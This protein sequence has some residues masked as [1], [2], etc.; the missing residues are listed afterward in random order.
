MVR[1]D[2]IGLVTETR[3]AHGVHEAI[4]ETVR[5]VLAEIRSVTRS[6]YYNALNAGIHPEM[7]FKLTLDADY[8]DERFLR[9]RGQKWRV[10]RTYLTRDGGIEITAER[11]DEN[12]ETEK[13]PA[14][15][16]GNGEG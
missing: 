1:A 16:T 14:D 6:E 10:V 5:E 8:H 3:S 15:D 2:V 13:E 4:T 11:D 7:V 12:G 9:F